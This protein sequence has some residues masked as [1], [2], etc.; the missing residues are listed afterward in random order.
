MYVEGGTFCGE[1]L[2]EELGRWWYQGAGTQRNGSG[3]ERGGEAEPSWGER[4]NGCGCSELPNSSRAPGQDQ[5][6]PAVTSCLCSSL[7]TAYPIQLSPQGH[8]LALP[9]LLSLSSALPRNHPEVRF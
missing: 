4:R 8:V 5:R 3:C 1:V 9:C 2:G 7:G 6:L